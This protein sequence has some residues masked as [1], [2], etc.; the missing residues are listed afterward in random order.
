ME[1]ELIKLTL[2]QAGL[3]LAALA[4]LAGLALLLRP[5]QTRAALE[6]FPRSTVPA[7]IFTAASLAWSAWLLH[8]T[9]LGNFNSWKPALYLLTPASLFL[10]INYMDE[11]L[12]PRALGGFLL[13]ASHPLLK[14]AQ[15]H[16]SPAR[17][18]VV[19]IAYAWII[20]GMALILS[21]YLFRR[22]T[23]RFLATPRASRTLGAAKLFSALILLILSLTLYP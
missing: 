2:Q 11:L 22:T 13:L 17:L 5:A 21:P 18:V 1:T 14:A 7:W 9:N 8:Q 4:L 23:Q 19:A 16:P 6:A 20:A 15:W 12:A 3:L 10:L